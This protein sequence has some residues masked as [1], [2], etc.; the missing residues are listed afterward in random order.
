MK[1]NL[2][3]TKVLIQQLNLNK[4]LKKKQKNTFVVLALHALLRGWKH[5]L[6]IKF[7]SICL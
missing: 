7:Y 4:R 2:A 6:M 5:Q 1:R 3:N